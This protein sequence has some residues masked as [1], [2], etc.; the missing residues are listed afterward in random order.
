M[1]M[2]MPKDKEVTQQLYFGDT[3]ETVNDVLITFDIVKNE[4]DVLA[5]TPCM[6]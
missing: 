1:N 3:C 6:V 5:C 2:H 4:G